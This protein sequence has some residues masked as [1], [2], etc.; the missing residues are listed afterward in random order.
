MGGTTEGANT[1]FTADVVCVFVDRHRAP[2]V[3]ME[4]TP[5]K[6]PTL[7]RATPPKSD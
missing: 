7:Q 4:R 5:A 2:I 1:D 3:K 6:N